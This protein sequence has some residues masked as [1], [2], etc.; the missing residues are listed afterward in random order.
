MQVLFEGFPHH[1]KYIQIQLFAKKCS[2]SF[3]AFFVHLSQ[4]M[5]IFQEKNQ[6][7]V[8]LKLVW[9]VAIGMQMQD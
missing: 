8:K 9:N 6:Y 7:T 1:F 5:K 4:N 3:A 2:T